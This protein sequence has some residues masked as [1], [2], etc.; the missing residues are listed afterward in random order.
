MTS[1]ALWFGPPARPLFGRFYCPPEGLVRAG[2]LLCPPFDLEAQEAAL[3]YRLLAEDLQDH[4]FAVLHFDYDGTGDSAGGAGDPDRVGAW[5]SSV[6]E[7]ANLLRSSGAR[8]I[9]AVGMRLGAALTAS[10]AARCEIDGLVLWDPCESGRSYLR[11][12]ALQRAVHERE[13][14]SWKGRRPEDGPT[15]VETLGSIYHLETVAQ[16]STLAAE[17]WP[18]PLAPRV[19][20][21]LRAERAPSRALAERL[22]KER[23][24]FGAAPGQDELLSAWTARSVV[25]HATVASI[26]SWLDRIAPSTVSPLQ[27]TA[28]TTVILEGP[29]QPP[30]VEKVVISPYHGLFMIS[31]EPE[32]ARSKCTIVLLNAGRTDH[33]GPGRLWVD[34]AR[35]WAGA[36]L[37][38]VRADLSGLGGSPARPGREADRAYPAGAVDDVREIVQSVSPGNPFDVVL[39]GLCSGGYHSAVAALEM[40]VRGVVAINPGFPDVA[41]PVGGNERL[42]PTAAQPPPRPRWLQARTAVT[43]WLRQRVQDYRA[44]KKVASA[45]AEMKWWLLNRARGE[46]RPAAIFERLANTGV[47]VL[48]IFRPREARV[49]SR[50]ERGT[51]RRLRHRDSFC[52]EVVEG[53]DHTLY[54]Q[55][56]RREI[57]P[58]LTGHVLNQAGCPLPVGSGQ[59]SHGHLS[60]LERLLVRP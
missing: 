41:G 48:V 34:L 53:S 45:A 12:Q 20:A 51:L 13:Q 30:V 42:V 50:G 38:V 40:P 18:A 24:E 1:R 10:V 44:L 55:R 59:E 16:M 49:F 36:G 26:V 32:A 21:L 17:D 27:V 7:A 6:V 28:R 4:R 39:V 25:P 60:G 37:R 29:A 35:Q 43:A 14:G 52:M 3:A 46:M 47:P 54:L 57:V 22:A 8:H 33:T 58:I 5:Q 2:V 9:F 56:S 31:T 15:D 23:A 11:E 19:L